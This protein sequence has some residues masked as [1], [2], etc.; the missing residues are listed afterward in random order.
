MMLDYIWNAWHFAAQHAGIAADLWPHCL[1]ESLP[2]AEFEK[3]AIRTL[4]LWVFFRFAVHMAVLSPYGANVAWLTPWLP[5][6]DPFML[7]PAVVLSVRD[8]GAWRR[9]QCGGRLLYIGSVVSLTLPAALV[10]IRLQN[11]PWMMAFF[12]AVRIF[13]AVRVSGNLQLVGAKTHHRHLV[14]YAGRCAPAWP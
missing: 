5:W 10:A 1:P 12:F 9:S 13:H 4:V 3:M 8:I 14:L 2:H 11:T 6:L 7:I